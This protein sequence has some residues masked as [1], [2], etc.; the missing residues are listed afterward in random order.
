[1]KKGADIYLKNNEGIALHNSPDFLELDGLKE[2]IIIAY[3]TLFK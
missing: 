3:T 2:L 1:M